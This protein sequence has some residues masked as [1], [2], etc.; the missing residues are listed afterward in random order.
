MVYMET[1]ST[2]LLLSREYPA[3]FIE[4]SG[5]PTPPPQWLWTTLSV[6]L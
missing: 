3:E 4:L 1:G 6:S 2:V 5:K